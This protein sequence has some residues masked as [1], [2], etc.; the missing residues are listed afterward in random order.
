MESYDSLNT[1]WIDD[2]PNIPI[3]NILL[4]S[5]KLDRVRLVNLTWSVTN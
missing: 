5:P 1:L 4:N 3:E 2:T